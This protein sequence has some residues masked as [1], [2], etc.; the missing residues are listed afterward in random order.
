LVDRETWI[1]VYDTYQEI[2]AVIAYLRIIADPPY[3]LQPA[4]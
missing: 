1:G 3:S 4:Q 2:K